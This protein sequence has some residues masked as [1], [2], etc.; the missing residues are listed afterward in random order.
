MEPIRPN[1]KR[2]RWRRL[3]SLFGVDI[4]LG[5]VTQYTF[6][7][8]MRDGLLHVG[9]EGKGYATFAGTV[10]PDEVATYL[11]VTNKVDRGNVCDIINAQFGGDTEFGRY[12]SDLCR[13]NV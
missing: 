13:E 4:A 10:Y 7:L 2:P 3:P 5:N 9:I 6:L 8:F 1:A 12:D 11:G